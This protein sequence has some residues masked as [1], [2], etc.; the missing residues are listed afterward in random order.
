M[1]SR[2]DKYWLLV[3]IVLLA[4]LVCGSIVLV[5]TQSSHKPVTIALSSATPPKYQGE[6]YIGGAVANPGYY[7]LRE[8]DTIESLIQATG[9]VPEAD[10]SHIKI[11]IP[12]AG[13]SHPPQRININRAEAWLLNALPGIGPDKSQAIVDYRNQH[14]PFQRIE[15]LLN[16]EGIGNSTLDR[17]R[18][19]ITVED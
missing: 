3:I 10:L 1:S 18:D 5:A 8:D 16:V 14:G 15:D 9:L 6:I 17:I 12:E 19:V 11:Y 4:S 7:P 2:L 13:E